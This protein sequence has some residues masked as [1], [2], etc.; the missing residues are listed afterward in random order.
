MPQNFN[1]SFGIS[2]SSAFNRPARVLPI[3]P[4]RLEDNLRWIC[5][6]CNAV[7][8]THETHSHLVNCFGNFS[9]IP[10][11]DHASSASPL[12]ILSPL[13]GEREF[14]ERELAEAMETKQLRT[15]S[16]K[17]VRP[18]T[19][20]LERPTPNLNHPVIECKESQ[21]SPSSVNTSSSK[22]NNSSAASKPLSSNLATKQNSVP[23]NSDGGSKNQRV[24]NHKK[25]ATGVKG[26]S[27]NED[28]SANCN[29][30][31]TTSPEKF[32]TSIFSSFK[33]ERKNKT[34][35]S[36]NCSAKSTAIKSNSK[37]SIKDN[38]ENI[39][40]PEKTSRNCRKQ[41]G[42]IIKSNADYCQQRR[43][44]NYSAASFNSTIMRTSAQSKRG[45]IIK[46][47]IC[48]KDFDPKLLA[49]H[50]LKCLEVREEFIRVY[51]LIMFK[52]T[53]LEKGKCKFAG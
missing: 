43:H 33:T 13:V 40:N 44:S 25:S 24:S 37:T 50:E 23:V 4:H 34:E 15:K 9:E 30:I 27:G 39:P 6:T 35:E 29:T 32:H 48:S 2:G 51:F 3:A 16:E 38:D 52:L 12:T 7:V 5:H 31:R 42:P 17:L 36:S 41:P 14:D 8:P 20:R 1:F 11:D 45:I 22:R 46:C 10:N 18:R 47:Y 26:T 53:A 49:S 19:K 21:N 28:S